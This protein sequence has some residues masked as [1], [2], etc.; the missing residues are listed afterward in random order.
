MDKLI[1]YT[2]FIGAQLYVVEIGLQE[3]LSGC[4]YSL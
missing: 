1:V 4:L 3:Y 2:W